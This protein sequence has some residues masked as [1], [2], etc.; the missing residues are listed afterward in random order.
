MLISYHWLKSYLDFTEGPEEVSNILTDCGLEVESL[1]RY[2]SVPGGLAGVVTGQV[3]SCKAHPNADK[4]TLTMVDV[5]SEEPLPIVCG[6]PNVAEGQKVLVAMVGSTLYPGGKA[7]TI[8]KAK[9]RGE[10]SEGMICAEDE[11]GMGDSH[12]GIMVLPA[13][14]PVGIPAA[15]YFELTDDWVF[16][17]GLTPNRIDAASH[18][19]VARDLAAVLNHVNKEKGYLLQ[20]PD[21]A[22]FAP[23][24]VDKEVPV[25]IEDP[26]ACPRYSSLTISGIRVKDSPAWLQDRLKAIG[27]KPINNVVDAT[28]F[29]LHELGQPLHAFDLEAVTGNQVIVKKSPRGTEFVTLDEE[30][31]ELSGEDLMICNADEPMCM[32]GILGGVHS[33]VT[34]RTSAIFLESACF[35]PVSIRR[36]AKLHNLKT[37]A[38][39]RFERGSDPEMTVFALKRAALLIKELAGGYISSDVHDVYPRPV[40]PVELEL[41]YERV[42]GLI[43]QPITPKEVKG[44]LADLDFEILSES[45]KGLHLRVPPYRVDVTRD[46]DVIEEILRIYGY[47]QVDVPPKMHTSMGVSPKPDKEHLQNVVS[48]M[49]SSRGFHEIMNNSLTRAAYYQDMG[50]DPKRSVNIQNPLSQDLNVMRQCLLFGGLETLAYNVNRKVSDMKLYEFGNVYQLATGDAP[51]GPLPGY[52]ERMVLALFLTGRSQPETWRGGDQDHD[53]FD[54]KQAVYAVLQ[55]MGLNGQDLRA[56]DAGEDPRFAYALD[57][58]AGKQFVVRMGQLS[59]AL[60]KRADMKGDV[61]YGMMEW[62][63]LVTLA[64]KQEILYREVPRYP[65]VRRDLALL[66]DRSVPFSRIE[67]IARKVEKK[68]L[69]SVGL[70]DVYQDDKLG[71]DK[72]SY[73]VS[74]VF[75]HEEKTLTDKEVDKVMEKLTKAYEQQLAATLR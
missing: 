36:S 73:A 75:Q 49:L 21:V 23:D 70:F 16:E 42:N 5:G 8:K 61:F 2:E 9:I 38:S 17:V 69:R 6:A 29:V 31:L 66:L 68:L 18:T 10:L 20:W 26:E 15:A 24:R 48:D 4:L 37:D 74:F 19:G 64:G 67:E 52:R 53:F 55:R 45:K 65:E 47:N 3:L 58:Y 62:D 40:K 14:T 43:G 71:K 12:E 11:L 57:L 13:V 27:L 7:L 28:N 33:G 50:F 34:A 41:A 32:G 35:S 1:H 22:G 60:L 63:A 59:K 72:K 44:I 25:T 30:T 39:F 56:E 46:A 51:P 54:L